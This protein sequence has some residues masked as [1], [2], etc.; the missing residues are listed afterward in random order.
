MSSQEKLRCTKKTLMSA[1]FQ[2]DEVLALCVLAH[3]NSSLGHVMEQDQHLCHHC[4]F[5]ALTSQ[6]FCN[7]K[8]VLW[9]KEPTVNM[10][11]FSPSKIYIIILML[12]V[13]QVGY[14]RSQRQQKH[15]NKDNWALIHCSH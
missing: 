11:F 5:P 7:H 1:A 10:F 6:S 9:L 2:S 12:I 13:V 3:L 14:Y 15:P 4:D 8:G